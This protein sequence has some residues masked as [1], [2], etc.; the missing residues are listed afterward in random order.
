MESLEAQH[1]ELLQ[2]QLASLRREILCG[3]DSVMAINGHKEAL[4]LNEDSEETQAAVISGPLTGLEDMDVQLH[5]EQHE[6]L[7]S[8][9]LELV[10]SDTVPCLES[11]NLDLE[12]TNNGLTTS[13]VLEDKQ[14]VSLSIEAPKKRNSTDDLEEIVENKVQK[15]S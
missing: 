4:E 2:A 8:T 1:K 13:K 12:L 15:I 11:P 10:P 3:T 5:T 9:E 6:T 7:K 14:E